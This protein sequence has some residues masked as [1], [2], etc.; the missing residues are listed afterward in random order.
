MRNTNRVEKGRFKTPFLALCTILI[1]L[2]VLVFA[3]AIVHR[4]YEYAALAL[5]PSASR[6]ME[7]GERHFNAKNPAAYNFERAA[8]FFKEAE[9]LDP[10]FHYLNHQLARIAF[11]R[12]DFPLALAYINKQIALEGTSTPNS[13]YVRG[14]I[15][16]YAGQYD[17]AIRDY[18]IFMQYAPH[19]WAAAN[20]YAWVLLKANK[21]AEAS[22]VTAAALLDFPDN[23]WLL[24]TDAIARFE[25]GDIS[26]ALESAKKAV[27]ASDGLTEKKWLTAYPGND[28]RSARAGIETLQKS[29]QE[30]L[31]RIELAASSSA[32]QPR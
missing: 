11:L 17:A 9:K 12:G 22:S 2:T 5:A 18:S 20:D 24:N 1:I 28:P 4:V 32:V 29:A 19:N 13:Y 31:R 14:L 10:N 23:P 27:S 30:N 6:A 3:G 26:R 7:Y 8:Y 25:V 16:G 15:E 21:P